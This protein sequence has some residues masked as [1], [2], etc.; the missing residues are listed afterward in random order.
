MFT[1]TGCASRAA[2]GGEVVT[3]VSEEKERLTKYDKMDQKAKEEQELKE[4]ERRIMYYE[5]RSKE[6][7]KQGNLKQMEIYENGLKKYK[8]KRR[9]LTTLFQ[10]IQRNRKSEF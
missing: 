6:E 7:K 2:Y 5:E 9:E 8:K 4:I 10:R 3:S 1:L